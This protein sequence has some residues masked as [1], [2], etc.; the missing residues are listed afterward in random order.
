MDTHSRHLIHIGYP[1]A[2]STTLAAWFAEN[3]QLEFAPNGIGGFANVCELASR[4]ARGAVLATWHV[5]SSEELTVPRPSVAFTLQ[6][7]GPAP[8]PSRIVEDQ[9]RVCRILER[10]FAGA[11]IL[12][13]TRGFRGE[14]ASV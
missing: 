5:T 4:A 7:P 6:D 14:L 11:T 2:G 8:P 1:K 10:M 3:P 12:V 13:V 9:E